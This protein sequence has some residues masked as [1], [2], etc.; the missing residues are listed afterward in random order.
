MNDN[1][2][3][4]QSHVMAALISKIHNAKVNSCPHVTL[5]GT[6]TPRRELMH[7]DDAADAAVFLMQHYSDCKPINIGIGKD[8]T[9]SEIAQLVKIVIG[10]NGEIIFDA[11]KP[12]G[13]P[14]KLLNVDK[15]SQMGWNASISLEDG[16]C[17]TYKS[18]LQ[19]F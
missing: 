15:L 16:I 11:S 18:Y 10:Y 2:D 9:I 12:D 4:E 19:R 14:Q 7:V 3:P 6:G 8:Y 13:V 1:Y 5:W 17:R